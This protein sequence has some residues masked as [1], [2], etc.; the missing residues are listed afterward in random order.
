MTI[1]LQALT[2]LEPS[3]FLEGCYS[4]QLYSLDLAFWI[5]VNTKLAIKLPS[6]LYF[7]TAYYEI[8]DQR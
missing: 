5:Y 6:T 1:H 2:L 7:V 3:K 4:V 8:L